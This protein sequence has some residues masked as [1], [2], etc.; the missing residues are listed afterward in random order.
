MYTVDGMPQ[1]TSMA[2]DTNRHVLYVSHL[3]GQVSSV[4]VRSSQV[5]GRVVAT[6][7]GLSSI[8]TSRGFAY[9]INTATRELAV[10][11][12]MSSAASRFTL[13]DEP[14]AVA[15]SEET[16]SVYVLASRPNAIV[17]IDPSDGSEIGR[18]LLPERSGRFGMKPAGQGEFQGLRPHILLNRYDESL[19]VTLPEAGT[20]SVVAHDQ[21]QPLT[22]AIAAPELG[23]A[24]ALST[25]PGVAHSSSEASN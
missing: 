8:A 22:Y 1:V 18:V 12:P 6:G 9:A 23:P 15:A 4:D 17:R 3:G 14:A 2:I 20:L 13:R 10:V 11:D 25:I 5:T 24:V 21:F 7:P 19:Y 16:G